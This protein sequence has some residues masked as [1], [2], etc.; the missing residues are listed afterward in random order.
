MF[1]PNDRMSLQELKNHN[2]L[3]EEL[4]LTIETEDVCLN[5]KDNSHLQNYVKNFEQCKA[6]AKITQNQINVLL[7]SYVVT[8]FEDSSANK[9]E[10]QMFYSC[11]DGDF[12]LAAEKICGLR[13]TTP[14]Y[15]AVNLRNHDQ[16]IDAKT[17]QFVSN[18]IN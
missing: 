4:E 10:E 5:S 6:Q 2:Y 12:N 14:N 7:D 3:A 17:I 1:D 15:K 8:G 18:F 16:P 9:S 13:K 11:I